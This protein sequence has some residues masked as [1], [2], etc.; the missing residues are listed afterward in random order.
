MDEI[1]VKRIAHEEAQI[2][3][4]K[5]RELYTEIDEV[6]SSARPTI[7]KILNKGF[8]ETDEDGKFAL[9]YDAIEVLVINDKA[10]LYG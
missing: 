1:D 8:L 4:D 7:Q 10:H 5:Y 9:T 2:V 3:C 6:W